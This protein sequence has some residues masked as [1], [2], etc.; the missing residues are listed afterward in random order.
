MPELSRA[1][2]LARYEAQP[3]TEMMP[4]GISKADGIRILLEELEIP[5]CMLPTPRPS[6]EVY[7]YTDP[8]F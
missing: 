7:G 3:Y 4:K 8:S 5:E 1:F 6:S 2:E